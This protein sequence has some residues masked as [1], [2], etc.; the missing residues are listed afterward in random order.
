[1]LTHEEAELLAKLLSPVELY[2]EILASRT[3]DRDHEKLVKRHEKLVRA[4]EWLMN[5]SNQGGA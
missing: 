1:M 2:A 5:Y 4:R 3:V